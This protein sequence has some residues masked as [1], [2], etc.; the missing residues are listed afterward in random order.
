MRTETADGERPTV[1][2]AGRVASGL[3]LGAWGFLF[4]FLLVTG[5]SSLY[6][7]TRTKWLVPVGAILLTATAAGRLAAS[8]VHA[9]EPLHRKEA[10][11]LGL[12]VVPVVVVL[13]LPPGA[14][15]SFAASRRSSFVRSGYAASA[16]DIAS[17]SLSL[18]D[19]AG[20]QTSKEG[21]RALAAR[22]GSRVTFVGFVTRYPNTPADEFMLTRFIITCCVADATIAQVR[23]VNAPPGKFEEDD[24][25]EVSGT[26]YPLGR[27]IL[28]DAS[29]V[30]AVPRPARPY[31]TP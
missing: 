18:I 6:L 25:V 12:M 17:G 21:E 19:V 10:W 20:A 23:V 9:P 26:I 24:W 30:E 4:W 5:R 8:R 13:A 2:S 1:W 15:G 27:E 22:A 28:V 16:S 31:L 14:L 3:T 7:S 11:L 29:S